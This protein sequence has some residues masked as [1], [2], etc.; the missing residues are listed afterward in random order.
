M[1]TPGPQSPRRTEP[2]H[3]RDFRAN[4]RV[5]GRHS[6][7]APGCASGCLTGA[8]EAS[9]ERLTPESYPAVRALP[10]IHATKTEMT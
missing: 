7:D 1:A 3:R 8:A 4:F 10:K 2:S 9:A 5:P 6:Q